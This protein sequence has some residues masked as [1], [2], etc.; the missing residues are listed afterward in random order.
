MATNAAM[1]LKT[2]PTIFFSN[3]N[4][5]TTEDTLVRHI[6]RIDKTIKF[7]SLRIVRDFQTM[8]PKGFAIVD[9]RTHED[10]K[11]NL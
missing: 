7:T 6:E 4:E 9:F 1:Q 11:W 3:L 5:E 2:Q 10:G 8:R